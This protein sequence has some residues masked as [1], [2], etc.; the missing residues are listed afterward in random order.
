MSDS[1]LVLP[2]ALAPPPDE[3]Q[4]IAA[5]DPTKSFLVQA[6]AGSGKTTLLVKRYLTLLTTVNEPEEILAIT[7]T[8]KAAQE[9]RARVIAELK[10]RS[11]ETARAAIQRS[12]DR[13]WNLLSSPQRMRIQTID[14]FQQGL[15]RQ[16][17]FQSRLSL[18]YDT[19]EN[20]MSLYV[21]AVENTFERIVDR[22]A[23][24][25][26][27]IAGMLASFDN[28]INTATALLTTMLTKR[29]QWIEHV[30]PVAAST[31]S[32]E[33]ETALIQNLQA[34]RAAICQ[35]RKKDLIDALSPV[36]GLWERCKQLVETTTD[37]S[38]SNMDEPADW[39]RLAAIFLTGQGALRKQ[40]TKREGFPADDKSLKAKWKETRDELEPLV[41]PVLFTKV[42]ALP[43]EAL[44]ETHRQDLTNYALTLLA[45]LQELNELFNARHVVDFTERSIA[46]RRALQVDDAPTQ[47]ALA[48][49][50]RIRHILV[51]EYQDTSIAQNEFLNLLMDGWEP[52][53]G[54]TFFAVG[55][56][57]QSIYTFRDADLSNFLK[58]D[59]GGIRN[60]VV[61]KLQLTANFRSSAHLVQWCNTTFKPI[62]GAVNDPDTGQVAFAE[63]EET[64]KLDS[65]A[66]HG[67]YLCESD[68]KALE[69]VKVAE[70]I[71]EL[72]QKYPNESIAILLRTRSNLGDYFAEFRRRNIRW[73]GIEME[74]LSNLPVVRDLYSLTC[75]LNDPD[76][77]QAW[78]EV[79]MSPLAGISMLDMEVL[80]KEERGIDTILAN[81]EEELSDESNVILNR[82]RGPLLSAMQSQHR[83]LRSR[84]ERAWFQLGGANPYQG[85]GDVS[86]DATV[87]TNAQHYLDT[88]EGV[89]SEVVDKDV[90]WER[91]ETMRATEINPS[92]DVEVMTI[93]TAKGLE[94][95]HVILPSLSQLT[96]NHSEPLLY[97]RNT[98]YGVAMSVRNS[99]DPD[100]MHNILFEDESARLRN[101]TSRLL[102]VAATR[103]KRT[104]WLFDT[105]AEGKSNPPARSLMRL[106]WDVTEES[107]WEFVTGEESSQEEL[108][109][110][111][112]WY[113]IDPNFRFSAPESLPII[114]SEALT[115]APV[116]LVPFSR[117]DVATSE[118][119]AIGQLVHAELQRMVDMKVIE[120]LDQVRVEW[121][122]NQLRARGF[123]ARQVASMIETAQHQIEQ[124]LA[125][126]VGRWLLDASHECSAAEVAYTASSGHKSRVSIVDRTFVENGIRWIVDYKTSMIPDNRSIPLYE[127]ALDHQPQLIRYAE[128]FERLEDRPIKAAI[129]FTDIAELIEIDISDEARDQ[130]RAKNDA[131][132]PIW[133][134]ART[135][136]SFDAYAE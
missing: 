136:K 125:S 70:K 110:V 65:E 97:A 85:T 44:T 21:E 119:M 62:L 114:H 19:V 46:A 38:Y 80:A 127:K 95:D 113:R 78:L 22:R 134:E 74:A 8:R 130:L 15:V 82:I 71:E 45:C 33:T 111:R 53:D 106:L 123:G 4:R 129:F 41:D 18:D 47:L 58:A 52:D 40:V 94:F 92:A 100:P 98:P 43:N 124:T 75:A 12:A 9:M 56:P 122:R 51:D 116:K 61:E 77:R 32:K 42:K 7:F 64:E 24:F 109:N 31:L 72:R 83:S 112:T 135:F 90:I 84:V 36:D 25:G 39:T 16:L 104:L 132:G 57:M 89:R 120:S 131:E 69:A 101:E 6:P 117:F 108:L 79:L 29:E 48:L 30:P 27:E 88:L 13:Q 34:V 128:L 35:Q 23:R 81:H 76:D 10:D 14:S 2:Q 115:E 66:T 37:D 73:R 20:A 11:T 126:E 96:E 49:D 68:D 93:H 99:T 63:S 91:L 105:L 50:Y 28:N 59:T 102:Y 26:D 3:D 67:L 121:W 60:R 133:D 118:P 1:A 103:A 87:K 17:P 54:N 5:V 55:D 86:S 107:D